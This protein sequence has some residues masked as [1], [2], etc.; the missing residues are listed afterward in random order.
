M[1]LPVAGTVQLLHA[2]ID[3]WHHA[4]ARFEDWEQA[5]QRS[6][7]LFASARG[8]APTQVALLPAIAPAVAAFLRRPGR[9]GLV[10]A[11][12]MEFRSLLLPALAAVGEDGLRWADGDYDAAGFLD[13]LDDRIGTVLVSSAASHDG[14]R[15]DL[16]AL[17]AASA[18]VGADLVIDSTQ[19]EGIVPL[20]VDYDRAAL[21]VASGYKGLMGPRGTAYGVLHEPVPPLSPSPYGMAD[22]AE[23]GSYGP[24]L[25]P[26]AD[27]TGLDF[28]PAWLSW[29]GAAAGHEALAA[30][31]EPERAD[32]VLGLAARLR[33]GL[34]AHGHPVRRGDWASP[35]TAVP[36]A[37]PQRAADL[38]AQHGIRAA[39]R[40][41]NLRLGVHW[42]NTVADVDRVLELAAELG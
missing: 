29:V 20:G 33:E 10:L 30:L 15:P 17:A 11:H 6:R 12:R 40:V 28:S 41:G 9:T 13:R 1:G 19:T 5:V 26:R 2:A 22:S 24:P 31:P 37:D 36:M 7:E 23:R 39:A 35:V 42:Y 14:S 16:A 8:L 32:H 18:A 4:R 34:A 21:V 38:L 25:R 27:A 3:D